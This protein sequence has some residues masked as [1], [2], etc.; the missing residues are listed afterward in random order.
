MH[1][2]S[3]LV[4]NALKELAGIDHDTI[5]SYRNREYTKNALVVSVAGAFEEEDFLEFIRDK[6]E[7]MR[8]EKEKKI[9]K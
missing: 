1:A 4:I 7:N 6:F 5:V 9:K 3:A 2:S 8:S